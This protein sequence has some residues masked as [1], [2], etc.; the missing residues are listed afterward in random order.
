MDSILLKLHQLSPG[1]VIPKPEAKGEFTIKGWGKR[2]GQPALVYFIPNHANPE[3]P[4]EKGVN[5]LEW[6]QAYRQLRDTGEFTRKWYDRHMPRCSNEGPCNFTT[7]GGIFSL[8]GLANY[9]SKGVYRCAVGHQAQEQ[10][11]LTLR[12]EPRATP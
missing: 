11:D 4:H 12:E 7:I 6:E 10:D 1:T 9:E 5:T 2:G 8:L 3:Q